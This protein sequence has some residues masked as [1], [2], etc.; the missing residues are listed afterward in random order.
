MKNIYILGS[1]NM[2]L[3]IHT[4]KMPEQGETLLG[5]SFMM[6]AG[7]K[8][9][10]QAVAVAKAGGNAKF[11]GAVGKTFS[12]ELLNTLA[13]YNVD[14]TNVNKFNDVASGVA[15]IVMTEGDNRIIVDSGANAKVKY[16][17]VK[18]ALKNAQIGDYLITQL[19]T[20]VQTTVET[21]K[22]AKKRGLITCLNTAPALFLPEEIFFYIDYICL[23]ELETM[24]YTGIRP[25][26]D[27]TTK[28]AAAILIAKGVKN[29]VIT[30]GKKGAMLITQNEQLFVPGF[31]VPTV[32]TTAAGDTFFGTL[33]TRIAG[34]NSLIEALRFASAASALC[35]TKNG[36]QKAIPAH[37]EVITFLKSQSK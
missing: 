1:V 23:N 13:K 22:F 35:I 24:F 31:K 5:T 21:F 3:V 15:V 33:I 6:N 20:P 9:A 7:G 18:K 26:N 34:Q 11:I 32:D 2:D 37:D 4:D 12:D 30:L 16:D 25:I 29:V 19:E 8:G 10:N 28:E 17:F 27:K 14:T 36:A